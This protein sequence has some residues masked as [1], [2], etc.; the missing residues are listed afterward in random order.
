MKTPRLD[1]STLA[2]V[3][4]SLSLAFGISGQLLMKA[5]ALEAG[6]SGFDGEALL[7]SLLALFV[8]GLGVLNWIFALRAVKLSV[9][10]PLSSLNYVGIFLGSFYLFGEQITAPRLFGVALIFVGVLLVVLRAD[11]GG[12]AQA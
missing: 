12:Q 2:Y 8:Y 11:G 1:T 9:A 4:L 5:A 10:Y 3:A 7:K 6:G